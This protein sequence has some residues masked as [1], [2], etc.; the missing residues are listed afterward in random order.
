MHGKSG[1]LLIGAS[2]LLCTIYPLVTILAALAKSP[3]IPMA[4]LVA[5]GVFSLLFIACGALLLSLCINHY[6]A[7]R[8]KVLSISRGN[9]LFYYGNT[10]APAV[11]DKSNI[12]T[13]IQYGGRRSNDRLSRTEIIF[14][15]GSSINVSGL[16]LPTD[17]MVAKFPHQNY[18]QRAFGWY[19]FIPRAASIPS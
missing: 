3:S 12:Q 9:P 19:F 10:G 14:K 5:L 1:F 13:I 11:Y 15:D 16:I 4:G 8:N 2:V 7:S 6:R 18:S 17:K